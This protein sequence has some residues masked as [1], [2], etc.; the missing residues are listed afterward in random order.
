MKKITL[1][2]LFGFLWSWAGLAQIPIGPQDGNTS[3][4]PINSCYN[5]SYSQQIIYQEE[6][7]AVPGDITSISFYYDSSDT[8]TTT[9]SSDWTIYVGHTTRDRFATNGAWIP[10]AELTQ[11]YS[12]TVS[13]PATGNYMQITFDDPFPYNNVDNLVVAVDENAAGS[14]C[15]LYFGKTA[16]LGAPRSIYYRNDTTNPDPAAPPV[17]SGRATYINNMILGGLQAS[18]PVPTDLVVSNVEETSVDVSWTENGTATEWEVLYGVSGFNP[19]TEGTL[20]NDT[21]GTPGLTISGLTS[22]TSYDFYVTAVCGVNDKSSKAG[23]MNF[24]TSCGGGIPFYESFETGY[25]GGQDLGDCW[26]QESVSGTQQWTVNSSETTYNRAPR[27]GNYNVYLRYGN[28]DWMFYALSLEGGTPYQ[29]SFYA[30]QDGTNGSNASIE[31]SYGTVDSASG[32]TNPIIPN[33]PLVN[34]D[35]QEFTG[36][37]TPATSGLYYI[38]I[39][40]TINSSP[41]YISLDDISIEDADGCLRPGNLAVTGVSSDLANVTWTE[42]GTATEWD[43]IYG[44]TGFDPATAGTTMRITGTA[45][46]TLTGLSPNTEYDFYVKAVCGTEESALGGPK[47]FT[48]S[49][50]PA[51][52]PFEEGFE[53]GYTHGEELA[54]CWSQASV[55]GSQ[56]WEINSTNT[57]YERTPRTGSYNVTLRYGNE[58]WMFYPLEL[59]AGTAYELSFYARQ[60]ST[61]NVTIEAAFG[62]SN[63]PAGMTTGIIDSRPVTNGDY[64]KFTGYFSPATTAT[65]FI[66]IKGTLTSAPWYLSVDDISV[67]EAPGCIPPSNL[68]VGII[69]E[70]TAEISWTSVSSET[71]WEV[72]YGIAGFDPE[73]AGT[74]VVVNDNPETTLTGLVSDTG[75]EYYVRAICGAGDE[76]EL[77]EA[78]Y[79]FTGYCEFTSTSTSYFISDFYTEGGI[80]NINN[81]NSGQSPNGYGN[82]TN[83][84]VMTYPTS[85]FDFNVEFNGTST[86]GFNMWIDFNGNMEFEESEKVYASG[87]YVSNASGT[88]TIPVTVP[89]GNYR[90]RIAADWLSTNPNACGSSNNAEVEDYTLTVGDIPSCLPPANLTTISTGEND[91]VVGWTAQNAETEWNVIYGLRGF[92]PATAGTTLVIENTPQA[93]I[94]GLDSNTVYDFYVKAICSDTDESA[95]AG[96]AQFR[97]TCGVTTNLPYIEDFD[98]YGTGPTAFPSCWERVTYT[99]GSNIWPSIVSVNST[100]SPNSL[101]FQS[102]VGTPTYAISPSFAED[103][104]N[105]RVSFM[106]KKE[107]TSSGT[108]DVGVMSDANDTSTFE[109][110][111]TIDPADTNYHE[112]IFN[113]NQTTLSGPNNY[114]ALRHNSNSNIWYYWLDDFV[115]D[116][117]PTCLEPTNLT[118]G[119][120]TE[121]TADVS[122][123][124]AED[125][126]QWEVTYGAAGFD[127][128][129]QGTTIVVN[130]NPET[131]LTGL[132][133]DSAYEFYVRAICSDDDESYLTG[134]KYFFTGYCS[135]TSTSTSYYISDFFTEEAISNITNMNSGQSPNGYGN[136]THMEV[137]TYPTSSFDFS[138]EFNGTSTYGFNMWIDFNG[139]MEFEESEKVYASGGYVS[140]ASGTVQ[141]PV[142]VPNGNYRMRIVADWLSTNP[143]ACGSRGN[144]E[145]EDYTV[146]I[147][148]APTCLP[149]TDLTLVSVD[150]DSAE[151]SWVS[152]DRETTWNVIYGETGFDPETQGTTIVVQDTPTATI[153]GLDSNTRYDVYVQAE[154][155]ADDLSMLTGPLS[156]YTNCLATTVPYLQDFESAIVPELPNCTSGE[157]IGNGNMW[158]TVDYNSNGFQ[159]NVLRYAYAASPANAWFYTQGIE[160]YAGVEYKISYKY[161]NVSINWTEKMKVAFGTGTGVGAMTT[162]LADYPA[163]SQGAR[164][165]ERRVGK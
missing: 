40:G 163:I 140:S 104:N 165:E 109:L 141:I 77:S 46:A 9:N 156:F 123:T 115:V 100:S 1:L 54:G 102:A 98:S 135:F 132:T 76:S 95:L 80:L 30:R 103:I 114:I 3:N 19:A 88:I 74:T 153:T 34:G 48:T 121:T 142:T 45:E 84:V 134:P 144:A 154:C 67:T 89:N 149:P 78:K 128:D 18:C 50:V 62:T 145:A 16:N 86:Y 39:K 139:N 81:M 106:L 57:T 11:V 23:P 159:G 137:V 94:T 35:Y 91:A 162:E 69:T 126:T 119:T 130:D 85:S 90:M 26:T 112:Y 143:V 49:C 7:N 99:S 97:T 8:S 38:G 146:T 120:V 124:E 37:F 164:S 118:V 47:S 101:R 36:Y 4:T 125:A 111:Q 87:S 70:D 56:F 24:R 64:Q 148:N 12:G 43:V 68:S 31:A 63:T 127:P 28:T 150:V 66:G 33:S 20:L 52:I 131:T 105:L 147:I 73:T 44:A 113:L 151:V 27:T 60:N 110:V 71:Q 53:T 138:V 75:Y 6:I 117:V 93:T 41:W 32:M 122:W 55:N 51:T 58:D 61:S 129:T 116:L 133:S 152:Q 10:S 42:S 92:D 5:Y 158:E 65:Y 157:R 155:E 82:F 72:T 13:F 2:I 160:M 15:T 29:L 108:I 59:T 161:G 14:N 17:A 107:G 25:V 21:D 96:P 83:M 136:F 79:F 22:N